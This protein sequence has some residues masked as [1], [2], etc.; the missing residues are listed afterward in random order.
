MS[1]SQISSSHHSQSSQNFN[2]DNLINLSTER[3]PSLASSSPT[4]QA[5]LIFYAGESLYRENL[6]GNKEVAIKKFCKVKFVFEA[7]RTYE[8]FCHE[9]CGLLNLQIRDLKFFIGNSELTLQRSARKP[10][11]IDVYHSFHFANSESLGR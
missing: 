10:C 4:S 9:F 7:E 8:S 3:N 5:H 2:D 1:R 6:F 11:E